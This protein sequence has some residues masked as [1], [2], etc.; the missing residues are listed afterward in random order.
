MSF[1][2]LFKK[3]PQP[4]QPSTPWYEKYAASVG[5]LVNPD[6][7]IR[8][9][10]L[11]GLERN[12]QRYGHKFCPC[13][14]PSHYYTCNGEDVCPC[15][16]M[17]TKKECHCGLFVMPPVPIKSEE[18]KQLEYDTVRGYV[19]EGYTPPVTPPREDHASEVPQD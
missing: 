4:Q 16:N 19:P 9:M 13:I 3:K 15:I 12:K 2:D 11:E 1:I 14:S 5:M 17:R 18:E 7:E 10:I 8:D 6:T